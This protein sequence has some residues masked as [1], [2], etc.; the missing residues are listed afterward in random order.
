MRLVPHVKLFH[1][2]ANAPSSSSENI[3]DTSSVGLASKI[4]DLKVSACGGAEHGMCVSLR[5]GGWY[6]LS[7]L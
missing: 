3:N 1:P 5:E 2:K 6:I 7:P 4:E